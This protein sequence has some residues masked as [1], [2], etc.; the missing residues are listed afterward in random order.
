MPQN[1]IVVVVVGVIPVVVNAR[2]QSVGAFAAAIVAQSN[3]ESRRT[4]SSLLLRVGSGGFD[5]VVSTKQG[6]CRPN[7]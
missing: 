1:I 3:V 4:V 6:R 2:R 5:D 7:E